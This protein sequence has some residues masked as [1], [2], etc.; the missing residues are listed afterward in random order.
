[1]SFLAFRHPKYE[2]R[3]DRSTFAHLYRTGEVQEKAEEA[4]RK[5]R[6]T[7]IDAGDLHLQRRSQGETMQAYRERVY[8]SRYPRHM[9]RIVTSF[10]GSLMQSDKK[11]SRQWG[12]TLGSPEEEDTQMSRY[13]EDADGEGTG[14]KQLL[15]NVADTLVTSH[16]QWYLV[17]PPSGDSDLATV[18]LIPEK[19]VVNWVTQGGR[20]VDVLVKE[21]R[22]PRTSI[23]DETEAGE[24]FIRYRPDGWTRYREEDGDPVVIGEG[25]WEFPFYQTADRDERRLPVGYVD[26]GLKE[27]VGY[28]MAKDARYLYNLLSDLRWAIRRTSFS[29]LA[30]QDEPLAREDY[31]LASEALAEGENFLTFPAQ[32]I[33]P[34]SAV[35]QAAY[36]IYKQEVK[37][38]YVTAL[39]SYEDS[40]QQKTATEI[41]QDQSSGRFS[42]LSVLATAMDE[43]EN[44]IYGLL[45]QI[46]EPQNPAS[47]TEAQV[48]RSRDFKP[49]NAEK[50]AD[51]LLKTY[52]GSRVPAS[53]NTKQ[54]VAKAVHD[55]LGVDYE[56]DDVEEAVASASDRQAQAQSQSQSFL[57]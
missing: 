11:A 34:D 7:R 18:N 53:D 26:L 15:Q 54:G 41:M 49:I 21:H 12:D 8:V 37:D 44:D 51:R 40:A 50:K 3:R 9:G 48:E 36:E 17:D 22:D 43:I 27:P 5:D 16:R 42:F 2:E 30:P 32:Y 31:E 38:F 24:T 10:V 25:E 28:R 33:A 6:G 56:D 1:M 13:F 39:Q 57:S 52:F 4:A 47:W 45:H 23:E 19:R 55:L 29:K 35:F 46:E 20:L 14:L